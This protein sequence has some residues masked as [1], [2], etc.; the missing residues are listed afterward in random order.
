MVSKKHYSTITSHVLSAFTI[1]M[2][3]IVNK[4]FG[5]ASKRYLK[6][7]SKT[8]VKINEFEPGLQKLSNAQL[9]AKTVYF[10]KL[11]SEGSKLDDILP[12]VFA[13]VREVSKR[14]IKLRHF[15][16]QLQGGIVLHKGMIAEMKTGEGKTLVATLAAYLNTL[17]G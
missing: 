1:K 12:E 14:T 5:S 9:Q 7:F 2:L 13:V 4:L 6:S 3:N 16:V 10:K 8:I 17:I 15:D 11:I